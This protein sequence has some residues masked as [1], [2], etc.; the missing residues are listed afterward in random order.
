MSHMK[1][2]RE[3]VKNC[4]FCAIMAIVVIQ[5]PPALGQVISGSQITPSTTLPDQNVPA[6]LS[7]LGINQIADGISSDNPPRNGFASSAVSGIITF[8]LDNNYNVTAFRLW[9]DVI[10]DSLNA[11]V[12]NFSLRFYSDNAGTNLLSTQGPFNA[13]AQGPVQV[14]PFVGPILGVRRV[15]LIVATSNN[16]IEIREVEFLGEAT[17]MSTLKVCKVAGPGV[18][19]NTRFNFTTTVPNH[20]ISV[21]AGPAPGGYCQV[22]G[23]DF[24]TGSS[25][26]IA[27]TV[28]ADYSVTNINCTSSA[29][30]DITAGTASLDIPPGV[31][32]CTFTNKSTEPTGYLEICKEMAPGRRGTRPGGDFTFIVNEAVD[33]LLGPITVPAGACSPAIEVIAGNVAI[34]EQ[35]RGRSYEM[36]DCSTVNVPSRQVACVRGR[37]TGERISL[38]EVPA[39]NLSDQTIAVITNKC[40]GRSCDAV[41]FEPS[42]LSG[43][44]KEGK[45]GGKTSRD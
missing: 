27:E 20:S 7:H 6:S 29:S 9:N 14:F 23:T 34:R 21:P 26:V 40:S 37:L 43:T 11:G 32:E 44:A 19:L 13:I 3:I 30:T 12:R 45:A 31:T 18:A 15:D 38:V 17:Q 1:S 24:V 35:P 5:M 36:T 8:N 42:G 2:I 39:G 10:I 22:V 41:I 28:P 33:P 25:V 4:I 16:S